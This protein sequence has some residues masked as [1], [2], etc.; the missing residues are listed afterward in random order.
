M[1]K[2]KFSHNL[3]SK[4]NDLVGIEQALQLNNIANEIAES[5]RLKRVELEAKYVEVE[6]KTTPECL[7]SF[8]KSLEDQA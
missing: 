7:N 5:N 8:T 3:S 2:Y 1:G 6:I 4:S